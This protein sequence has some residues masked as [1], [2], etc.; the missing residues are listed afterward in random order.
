MHFSALSGTNRVG[1]TTAPGLARCS[2]RILKQRPPGAMHKQVTSG[3]ILS[4]LY[5]FIKIMFVKIF[6]YK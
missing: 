3:F 4:G 6:V 1:K 2:H 5:I